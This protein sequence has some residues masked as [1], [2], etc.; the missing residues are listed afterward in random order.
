MIF[1]LK[2]IRIRL[3][4]ITMRTTKGKDTLELQA[5]VASVI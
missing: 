1:E 4:T 5:G 3:A 2:F